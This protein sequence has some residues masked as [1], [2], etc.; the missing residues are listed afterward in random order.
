MRDRAV[1][2]DAVIRIMRQAASRAGVLVEH[3]VAALS[4]GARE[5]LVTLAIVERPGLTEEQLEQVSGAEPAGIA[6]DCARLLELKLAIREFDR[7]RLVGG[8]R[9]SVE[10]TIA[11]IQAWQRAADQLSAF[12]QALSGDPKALLKELGNAFGLFE[13]T[14]AH[15]EWRVALTVSHVLE[16]GLVLYGR[17]ECW[18]AWRS[19]RSRWRASTAICL[20]RHAGCISSAAKRRCAAIP[21]P[22]ATTSSLRAGSGPAT[23]TAS[24]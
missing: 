9:D 17:W 10:D 14:A 18:R 12:L 3:L 6:A 4:P 8:I 21:S 15:Q 24:H 1:A 2:P 16:E 19:G 23:L 5:L 13:W 11:D 20:R 22:L 7:I